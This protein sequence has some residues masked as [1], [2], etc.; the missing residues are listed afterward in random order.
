LY[1]LALHF[2]IAPSIIGLESVAAVAGRVHCVF[3][4]S[5]NFMRGEAFKNTHQERRSF[6]A[7]V[8]FAGVIV[9]ILLGVL[10]SRLV[11][12]Q[13]LQHDYFVTRSDDNR[14]RAHPIPSVRGLIYDRNG[15]VLAENLP[16]YRLELIPE[17]IDDLEDTVVRLAQLMVV[18]KQD[19]ERFFA[20]VK[21]SPKF[22]SIPLK[23]NMNPDDVAR[24]EVN[25]QQFPGVR[26]RA[27]LTRHY[28]LGATTAHIIGYVGGI[29]A[30]DLERVD[31]EQYRGS[32]YIGKTGIEYEYEHL[33]HGAPGRQ[34]VEANAKGRRLRE[35]EYTRAIPGST[36]Y[37]TLDAGL[38]LTTEAAFEGRNGAAVAIDPRNGEILAMVSVPSFDPSLFVDGI[39]FA[40]YKTLTSNKRRPLFHRAIQGQYPPGSTIKPLMALAGLANGILTP[41]TRITCPGY[42]QLPNHTRRHRDWKR[43]GHDSMNMHEAIAQSCDVYFYDLAHRLEIDRIHD[44]L[45]QFGLGASTGID[46]PNE[47]NGLLP[48]RAWKQ[49]SKSQSWF[50]GETLNIGI[51]QG[52]MLTTPLQLALATAR[53][54]SRGHS[55]T[56][57][58]LKSSQPPGSE[59]IQAMPNSPLPMIPLANPGDWQ[60]VHDAMIAVVHGP[61]GTARRIGHD[62]TFRFA[63][64]TGTAQV[65][66][67]SQEDDVAPQLSDV[68]FKLRDHSLFIAFA[69]ADAPT[70]A[71]AVIVEHS[72][73]GSAVAAPI[74]RKILDY[75]LTIPPPAAGAIPA[76][77]KAASPA[78]SQVAHP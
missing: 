10:I 47:G 54:A 24:I 6:V 76:P 17:Q 42:Y 48:S 67:L 72:G 74:G 63:G 8:F 50:P 25:R 35:L 9:L 66:G 37:L 58:L 57:H 2:W 15:L 60:K 16:A 70:I 78:V 22:D 40:A 64:K 43:R 34:L 29:T 41:N 69:P 18:T 19:Q 5:L 21:T 75:A 77:L 14:M 13:G 4:I 46:L 28:P 51:G 23:L 49:R 20:R 59:A 65:A 61:T 55:A 38:Q 26:V 3:G 73:S 31:R 27:G 62:A 32:S 56:P 53:V 1:A 7:R 12:L 68:E 44:F 36:L 30:N 45:A 39:S 52:F 71:L 33:L 11:Q